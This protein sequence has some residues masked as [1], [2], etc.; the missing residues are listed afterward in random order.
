MSLPTN[1]PQSLSELT[2]LADEIWFLSGDL[3]VDTSWYT[4]RGSLA[5]I[6]AASELYQTQDTSKEFKD[7]EVFL[8]S[9]LKDLKTAG[10]SFRAV[11]EWASFSAQS[12]VNIL[13][14]KGV[15]I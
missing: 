14:S 12:V 15:R 10:D 9:R 1:V 5:A 2:K 7:T 13:R 11:E 8:D 3:S 4:K 6:Y